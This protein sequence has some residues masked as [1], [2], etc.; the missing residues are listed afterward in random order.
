MSE[1]NHW[2]S[3]SSSR[4]ALLHRLGRLREREDQ[5]FL[6]LT[7]VIGRL[8][9]LAVV[10]FILLTERIGM[11][12]YPPVGGASWRRLLFPILGSLGIGYL[13]FR[14]F[15]AARGSGVPQTKFQKQ[16][17]YEARQG[18]TFRDVRRIRSFM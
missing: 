6:I 7:L 5:V 1:G 14:Y 3:G 16:P 4:I 15:P 11:R 2:A 9:G 18:G 8:T 10:A 17:L 13:L 12:L